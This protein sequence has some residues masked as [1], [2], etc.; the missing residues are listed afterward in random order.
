MEYRSLLDNL[1]DCS[2]TMA[3][4]RTGKQS[5]NGL[6]CLT[7]AANHSTH[8][9]PSKLKFEDGCSAIWNFRQDHVVRKF[10]QLANDELEKLS[11]VAKN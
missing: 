5:A 11:H 10:Y 1:D 2:L 7:A 3:C 6:Y 9:A 8:V 4:C